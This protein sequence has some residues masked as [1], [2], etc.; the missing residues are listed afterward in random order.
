MSCDLF[1]FGTAARTV[2][3]PGSVGVGGGSQVLGLALEECRMACVNTLECEGIVFKNQTDGDPAKSVC[4]GKK[5]IHTSRC[6]AGGS[7][8]TE[9]LRGAPW[10]KCAIFG[11]P[12]V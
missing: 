12:H 10:G 8:V 2:R 5:D 7:Y 3:L 4:V 6:Q 11:D 9:V 1:C